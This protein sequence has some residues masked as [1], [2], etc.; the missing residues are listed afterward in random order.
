MDNCMWVGAGDPVFIA[1]VVAL[2]YAYRGANKEIRNAEMMLLEEKDRRV[3]ELEAFK[4]VI[5]DRQQG[6]RHGPKSF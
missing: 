5:E 1:A 3:R 2:W 6:G 4:K